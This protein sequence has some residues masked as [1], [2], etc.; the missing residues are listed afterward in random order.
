[1]ANEHFLKRRTTGGLFAIVLVLLFAISAHI[2]SCADDTHDHVLQTKAIRSL[3]SPEDDFGYGLDIS[4]SA[5]TNASLFRRD[6]YSCSASNPCGNGA[7][8]G[9]SGYCG[10]GECTRGFHPTYR[11]VA[12]VQ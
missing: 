4:S 8:C 10:Y 7:C 6:D 12:D 11:D 2:Y 1:M 5:S 9:A 3:L